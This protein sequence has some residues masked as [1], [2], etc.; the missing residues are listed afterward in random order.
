MSWQT[1]FALACAAVFAVLVPGTLGYTTA[2]LETA[3]QQR[4][5]LIR[6]RGE[7]QSARQT[8]SQ[9]SA[10]CKLDARGT[11]SG[12]S[13][14]SESD[15]LLSPETG[16]H[17]APPQA[18]SERSADYGRTGGIPPDFDPGSGLPPPDQE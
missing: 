11:G 17:R 1:T 15:A 7:L 13:P 4:Q 16:I 18:K 14:A 9:V 2:R 3:H 5:E 10:P 6:L 8:I 12:A